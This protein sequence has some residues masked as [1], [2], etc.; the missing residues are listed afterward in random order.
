MVKPLNTLSNKWGSYFIDSVSGRG[1]AEDSVVYTWSSKR[2]S[3]Y[4]T[5]AIPNIESIAGKGEI[6]VTPLPVHDSNH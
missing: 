5:I 6:A 4:S 2:I 3:T 1:R